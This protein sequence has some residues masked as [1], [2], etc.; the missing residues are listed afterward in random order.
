MK[1]KPLTD[2]YMLNGVIYGSVA[3]NLLKC[4]GDLGYMRPYIDPDDGNTYVSLLTG[5]EDDDGNPERQPVLVRNDTGIFFYDE[6]K[7]IDRTMVRAAVPRLK[8]WSDLRAANQYTVPGGWSKLVV[9]SQVIGDITPAEVNM[10]VA[11]SD[12]D[13]PVK[14]FVGVP[15]PIIHKDAK[16]SARQLDVSRNGNMPLDTTFVELASIKVAE[17][18]EKFTVG[19]GIAYSFAGNAIYGYTNFPGRITVELSDP[20]DPSWTPGTMI[21][22]LIAMRLAA[23]DVGFYGPFRVYLGRGWSAVLDADYSEVK[24]DNTLR[25]RALNLDGIASIQ[26]LDFMPEYDIVMVQ[27]GDARTARGVVAMDMTT[28]QWTQL[29]GL[30]TFVKIMCIMVPQLRADI[31]GGIG[32]VHGTVTGAGS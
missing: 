27:L 18:V 26:T 20:T 29:G 22:E 4:R 14:D 16:F 17:E 13:S 28:M 21:N 8:A 5:N 6:W 24:G 23:E 12:M 19:V 2:S 7:D 15:L 31:Y 9:E 30:E 10:D 25:Q 32:L 3:A 1:M 11:I